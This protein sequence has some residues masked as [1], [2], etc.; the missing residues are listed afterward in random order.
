MKKFLVCISAMLIICILFA[1]GS[2]HENFE[3]PVNF[4]Y[5]TAAVTYNNE[6]AVIAAEVRDGAALD[7]DLNNILMQYLTG[8]VSDEFISPFPAG[9]TVESL[10]IDAQHVRIILSKPFDTLSGIQLTL[11]CTCLS[12][13]VM[14]LAD[15]QSV[16]ISVADA[17]LDGKESIIIDRQAI[18]LMDQKPLS[19]G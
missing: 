3:K 8:P 14:E 12:N 5:R 16:E 13:T 10:Q 2:N 9:V 15:C 11:A 18:L 1:C 7:Q 19:E 17:L 6:Q 4:Y